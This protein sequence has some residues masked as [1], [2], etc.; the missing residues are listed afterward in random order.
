MNC[1]PCPTKSLT[2]TCA[3]WSFQG[4]YIYNNLKLFG[5]QFK[6]IDDLFIFLTQKFNFTQTIKRACALPKVFCIVSEMSQQNQERFVSISNYIM[7]RHY[8]SVSG[9]TIFMFKI[10]ASDHIPFAQP[11][12]HVMHM[13]L[14]GLMPC[15]P[16]SKRPAETHG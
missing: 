2:D 9:Y 16:E 15:S 8:C 10:P 4:K 5:V 7:H 13:Q 3:Q 14:C 6:V 1:G 11:F 12:V